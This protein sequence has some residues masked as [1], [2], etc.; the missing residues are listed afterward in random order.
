MS[1]QY[2]ICNVWMDWR[3]QTDKYMQAVFCPIA[4]ATDTNPNTKLYP[5]PIEGGGW[6][7]KE[8]FCT[9]C[10]KYG[11]PSLSTRYNYQ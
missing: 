10:A 8:G 6:R 9:S 1:Q 2:P 4:Q 5:D 11:Q 3:T 7:T